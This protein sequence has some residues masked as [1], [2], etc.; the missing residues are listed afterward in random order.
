MRKGILIWVWVSGGLMLIG[1]FGPWATVFGISVDGTNGDG[2]VVVIAGA[3]AGGL[4]YWKRERHWAGA[5][6]I[7]GGAVGLLTTGYD[8]G[9]LESVISRGGSFAQ[10]LVQVGWGLNLALIASVSMLVAGAVGVVQLPQKDLGDPSAVDALMTASSAP[11]ST[12]APPPASRLPFPPHAA[13]TSSVEQS[14]AQE[15]PDRQDEA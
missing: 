11:A 4:C 7:A 8:R 1:G 5:W 10:A 14:A 15:A 3:L 13:A 9:H 12:P 2:W 6:A